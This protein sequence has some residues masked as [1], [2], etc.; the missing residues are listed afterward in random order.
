[1]ATNTFTGTGVAS[2]TSKWSLGAPP[3]SGDKVVIAASAVC[4]LDGAYVWGDDTATALTI[5]GDLVYSRTVS[6]SLS[7]IGGTVCTSGKFDM[8]TEASPIPAAI[9]AV[10]EFNRSASM[11]NNKYAFDING[12]G[13]RGFSV[14]GVGKTRLTAVTSVGST[15]QFVVADATG[16]VVGDYLYMAPT[17]FNSS[18][19]SV[20]A[21]TN[22]TPGSGTSATVTIGAAPTNATTVG[23]EIVNFS[24][25]VK[26]RAYSGNTHTSRLSLVGH[27]SA[28]GKIILGPYEHVSGASLLDHAV[29]LQPGVEN[30]MTVDGMVTHGVY[31]V[32]GSTVTSCT[33]NGWQVQ[34][35][36]S[37]LVSASMSNTTHVSLRDGE[38]ITYKDSASTLDLIN[39]IFCG[40]ATP[41]YA[42]SSSFYNRLSHT[43]P[44]IL[45]GAV[46]NFGGAQGYY[47][48][49]NACYDLTINGGRIEGINFLF[50]A[51]TISGTVSDFDFGGVL[52]A[53]TPAALFSG[54]VYTNI[55]FNRCKW[56]GTFD[57]PRSSAGLQTAVPAWRVESLAHNND[58]TQNFRWTRA[59]RAKSE[60]T[61][62]VSGSSS[63]ALMPW[64]ANRANTYSHS[65]IL[66]PGAT[67]PLMGRMRVDAVTTSASVTISSSAF[68]DMVVSGPVTAGVWSPW[69]QSVTN[70]TSA[71]LSVKITY[72]ARSTLSADGPVAYFDGIPIDPYVASVRWYGYVFD[73]N[74]YRTPDPLQGVAPSIVQDISGVAINHTTKTITVTAS[75]TAAEVYCR[76]MWDLTQTANNTKPVHIS[77]NDG[78][79]FDTTY[80]VII[81][82]GGSI[83]GRYSDANGAVVSASL[84]GIVPM[85]SILIIRT[86]TQE[87][88]AKQIVGGSL[89]SINVQTLAA[90]PIYIVVRYG[91]DP[92]YRDWE[93]SGVI[94]P[95]GGFSASVTQSTDQ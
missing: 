89:F 20:R 9:T 7:V 67:V 74:T 64:Y 62:R 72:S 51:G 46:S 17:S 10:F 27:A 87:I 25:N 13:F 81:G 61:I 90:I 75:R 48:R 95:V 12:A 16:W 35:A 80:T 47:P 40:H 45:G 30:Q 55:T 71:N 15:T 63:L 54:T 14:V 42:V 5:S 3:V 44:I 32:S 68:S 2:D 52:G 76:A 91:S 73:N 66:P 24:R 57:I 49:V 26:I 37:Y 36:S 53:R 28:V 34:N 33:D 1:M 31:S 78:V 94:D 59:G 50:N 22:I 58:P 6:A 29:V 56:P 8:G 85:S 39:P 43:N 92:F 38:A 70:P 77:S 41:V 60:P 23:R 86:D 84:S 79:S 82:A 69:L 11:S 65:F 18:T 83:A 21:I 93:T 4:T 19:Q 88:L